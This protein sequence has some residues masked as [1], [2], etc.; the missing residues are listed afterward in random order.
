MANRYAGERIVTMPHRNGA[1]VQIVMRRPKFW[2][3]QKYVTYTLTAADRMW[4]L[5]DKNYRNSQDWWVIADMNPHIVC[6]DDILYGM[7]ALIPVG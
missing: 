6:P 7:T 3:D 2:R 4:T 1:Q 5:A